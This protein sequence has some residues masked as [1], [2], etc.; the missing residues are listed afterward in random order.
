MKQLN[1]MVVTMGLT[2]ALVVSVPVAQ[3]RTASVAMKGSVTEKLTSG[4]HYAEAA[5]HYQAGA[6]PR[7]PSV[8]KRTNFLPL[9]AP[10]VWAGGATAAV[11]SKAGSPAS[12]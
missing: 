12:P 8:K 3:A 1:R 11:A 6:S 10:L 2:A 5:A 9:L 4:A 7:Q